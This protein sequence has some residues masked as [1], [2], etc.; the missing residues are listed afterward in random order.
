MTPVTATCGGSD[1]EV[2]VDLA[3]V[4]ALTVNGVGYGEPIGVTERDVA[5]G[6]LIEQRVAE[7]R[8]ELADPALAIDQGDFSQ[9]RGALVAPGVI[10]RN[11]SAP[12]SG[13]NRHRA[14][15]LETDPQAGDQHAGDEQRLGR[16]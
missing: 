12:V 9:E 1:H 8:P 16:S 2:D 13:V 11:V 14:A 5:G 7:H 3:V 4:D 10:C 6:V 15:I